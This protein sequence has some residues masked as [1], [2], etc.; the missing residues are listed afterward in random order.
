ML[1]EQA[2]LLTVKIGEMLKLKSEISEL[3]GRVDVLLS[4]ITRGGDV[5][6]LPKAGWRRDRDRA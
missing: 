5:I 6:D 1:A 4:L 3:K 2:I